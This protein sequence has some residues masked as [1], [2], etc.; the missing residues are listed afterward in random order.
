MIEYIRFKT[1]K[2]SRDGG[3]NF[4]DVKTGGKVKKY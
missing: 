3:R 4:T 2:R 1:E